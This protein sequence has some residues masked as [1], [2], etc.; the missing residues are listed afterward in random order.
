MLITIGVEDDR[1]LPELLFKAV[2]IEF[3]LLLAR[4][5]IALCALGLDKGS[6]PDWCKNIL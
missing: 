6:R 1:A 3:R 5:R 4:A 2:G